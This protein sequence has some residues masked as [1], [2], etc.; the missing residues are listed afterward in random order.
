MVSRYNRTLLLMVILLCTCVMAWGAEP[1]SL[2][3]EASLTTTASSGDFAPYYL[4]ANRHGKLTQANNVLLDVGAY[5]LIDYDSRFSYSFGA[6]V[7]GG[8]S[9]PVSYKRYDFEDGWTVNKCRPAPVFLQQLYATVKWRGVFLTAGMCEHESEIVNFRLS[10]GDLTAS[11]NARPVPEVR[12]GFVDFQNIP[13]TNGWVQIQGEVSYGKFTDNKWMRTH[14]NYY[15]YHLAADS[16]INYKRCYFRTKPSQPFSVTVGMQASNIFGGY[17]NY[18]TNGKLTMKQ[19][20]SA[21]LGDFIE[22]FM[23]LKNSEDFR[24]GNSL[25]SWDFKARYRLT[26]DDE[27]SFYFEKPWEDGS[28][29]GFMNGWDGV[30]GL[31]YR[32][33]ETGWLDGIVAEYIDFTNQSGPL[34]WAPGDHPGTTIS[35]PATGADDYYNNVYQKPYCNYGLSIGTPFLKAPLFNTDGYMRYVTNRLRGFHIAAE[36]HPTDALTWRLAASCRKAWGNGY[37]MLPKPLSCFS[38]M[39]ECSYRFDSIPGLSLKGA[40]AFDA[41][42]LL[43]NNLGAEIAVVYTGI[44]NPKNKQ[45]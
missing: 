30:W 23:P 2:E 41:G 27:L 37:V 8:V 34:H 1:F 5:K 44:F 38:M 22:A 14:F 32:S 28:G 29:I 45:K 4:N 43:G 36:G 11:G 10:S 3:Y 20:Y 24:Y 31:E 35:T 15:N 7:I 21:N 6:E 16:W 18:Y 19:E 13:L 17:S 40:A 39:L 12:I 25:G 42:T 33:S 26:N 9:S